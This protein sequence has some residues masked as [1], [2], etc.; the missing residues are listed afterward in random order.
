MIMK[1]FLHAFDIAIILD[2]IFVNV[3]IKLKPISVKNYKDESRSEIE[4]KHIQMQYNIK[5]YYMII[6]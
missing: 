4:Q 1:R 3:K 2:H 6:M 5:R